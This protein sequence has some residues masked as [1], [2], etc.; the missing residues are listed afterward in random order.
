MICFYGKLLEK[1]LLIGSGVFIG[2]TLLAIIIWL[3]D[4]LVELRSQ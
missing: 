1:E 4:I 2:A 3:Y